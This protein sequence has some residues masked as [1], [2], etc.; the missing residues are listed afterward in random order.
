MHMI[1]PRPLLLCAILAA[2]GGGG[3]ADD[4][5]PLPTLPR[6]PAL[7]ALALRADAAPL[8]GITLPASGSGTYLGRAELQMHT[9]S[10]GGL[11]AH[12]DDHR[13]TADSA[14]TVQFTG[15]RRISGELRHFAMPDAPAYEV[16]GVL[17]MEGAPLVP[18]RETG[19]VADLPLSGTLI[20]REAGQPAVYR[21]IDPGGEVNLEL[22]GA[23]GNLVNGTVH[24]PSTTW[25]EGGTTGNISGRIVAA[26]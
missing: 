14:F 9:T 16:L 3:G 8:T 23:T 25:R 18:Y 4:A 10:G 26:R 13:L 6:D 11:R 1:K 15:P 12:Q 7:R 24:A 17:S 19:L 2:C 21:D 22:R 20:Y 5:P